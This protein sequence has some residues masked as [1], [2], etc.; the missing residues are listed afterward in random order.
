[1]PEVFLPNIIPGIYFRA[2]NDSA[3]LRTET[4]HGPPG[5]GRPGS[6]LHL[7]SGQRRPGLVLQDDPATNQ[8]ELRHGLQDHHD[9]HLVVDIPR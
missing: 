4:G 6:A 1:M 3:G 7:S 9:L 8:P 2:D 5:S